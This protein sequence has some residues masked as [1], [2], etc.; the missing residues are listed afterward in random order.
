MALEDKAGAK[1]IDPEIANQ[2]SPEILNQTIEDLNL[3]VR[4]Y[5]ALD[6]LGVKTILELIN[7]TEAELLGCKNF[8]V[9]SLN[10][11]KERLE[12]LGLGLRKLE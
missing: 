2:A 7:K 4:A 9:T 3:S 11:I 1:P 6:R 12:G 10:E 5:R 8:G